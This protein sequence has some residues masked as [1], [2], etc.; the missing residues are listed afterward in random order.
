MEHLRFGVRPRVL[1]LWLALFFLVLLHAL[2]SGSAALDWGSVFDLAAEEPGSPSRLLFWEI[3]FPRVLTA[4]AVGAGLALVGATLQTML[5]N[6]LADPF[7][8]GVSSSAATGAALALAFGWSEG[9]FPLSIAF[10]LVGLILLDRLSY[11]GGAFS[12]HRL[13]VAG[14]TLTYLLSAVTGLIIA[15]ADSRVSRGLLFWLMGGFSEFDRLSTGLCLLVLVLA[16]G[17]LAYRADHLDLLAAGDETAHILGLRPHRFRRQLF[18]LCSLVIGV[19]VATSGGI[20]F[21]GVVIPHLARLY[22]G[23]R[24]RAVLILCALGGG[25]LTLFADTLARTVIA[26]KELPVGLI[27]ALIGGPYF[28]WQLNRDRT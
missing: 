2:M 11:R 16:G 19:A 3:R 28:L 18:V 7:L 26:P 22:C 14:F 15:L 9:R 8:L 27:T 25:G 12:D 24:H 4:L 5:R 17:I 1:A 6:P 13:L 20:G 10:A 21:V 23:V